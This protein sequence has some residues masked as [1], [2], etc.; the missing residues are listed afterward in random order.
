MAK[1]VVETVANATV[2]RAYV[3]GAS[4]DVALPKYMEKSLYDLYYDDFLFDQSKGKITV[5]AGTGTVGNFVGGKFT[6]LGASGVVKPSSDGTVRNIFL[7]VTGFKSAGAGRLIGADG[8][9][10]DTE[11][12]LASLKVTTTYAIPD[13]EGTVSFEAVKKY[14]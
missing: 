5:N 8:N 6:A 12:F 2:K 7:K 4:A 10:M 13:A 11:A 14:H 9:E 3:P 1:K